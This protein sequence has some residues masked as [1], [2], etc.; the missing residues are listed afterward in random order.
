MKHLENF[1][2]NRNEIEDCFKNETFV[3]MY[4]IEDCIDFKSTVPIKLN[5]SYYDVIV[6]FYYELNKDFQVYERFDQSLSD[7][8]IA[9]VAFQDI[10]QSTVYAYSS[11]FKNK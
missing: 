6:S 5:N 7:F 9:S 2:K 10:D 3:F 4:M 1:F 11:K 8:Q